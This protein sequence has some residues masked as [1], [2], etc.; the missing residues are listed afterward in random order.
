[1]KARSP[2]CLTIAGSDPSG[3][4]GVQADLK[5][6]HQHRVYGTAVITLL[7]VQNTKSVSAVRLM[8]VD[9]VVEQLKAI[10][11]DIP[12]H[13]AKTG[14]L[15]GPEIVDAISSKARE[16]NFPLVVDPVM[17][18][19]HGAKLLDPEAA[20]IFRKRLLPLAYL[21]TPNLREAEELS[22]RSVET[23]AQMEKAAVSIA[24]LGPKHVLIKG[25]H[26]PNE[27]VDILYTGGTCHRL[28][29]PRIETRNTHGTGCVLSAAITSHLG[30]GRDLP[31]AVARAKDFISE[32]IQTAPG[33]GDGAGP[34]NMF[35]SVKVQ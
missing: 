28:S 17:V 31:T 7:T 30:Y 20:E 5:T 27:P 8:D 23:L 29:A 33:L 35:A 1:M 21:V 13:A 11:D 19:K 12:P 6:F 16:F 25:G 34:V 3:G 32:A 10:L 4:A 15:G 9:L 22:E 2:I 18:S 24:K 26:L 14:A